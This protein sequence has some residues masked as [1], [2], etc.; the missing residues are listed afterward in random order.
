MNNKMASFRKNSSCYAEDI[1]SD[2]KGDTSLLNEND[3]R[4]SCDA[5]LSL[6]GGI[7]RFENEVDESGGFG[8]KQETK[9]DR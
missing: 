3:S 5:D 9:E 7:S 4:G 6:D 8:A 1:D 2:E